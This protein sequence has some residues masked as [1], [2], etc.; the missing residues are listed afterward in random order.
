MRAR[1]ISGEE[2]DGEQVVREEKE[3]GVHVEEGGFKS[4]G[5]EKEATSCEKVK[6]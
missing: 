3:K 5:V 4:R 1:R 6:E 2:R